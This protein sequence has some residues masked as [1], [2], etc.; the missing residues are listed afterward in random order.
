[1]RRS[2]SPWPSNCVGVDA[3]NRIRSCSAR[4]GVTGAILLALASY[5]PNAD[6][7]E[8]WQMTGVFALGSGLQGGDVGTGHMSFTRARLRVLAGVDL[9]TDESKSDGLGIYGFTEIEHRASFGGEVR[10]ERWWTSTIECH[11]MILGTVTPETMIGAG[12]GA[13]FGFPLGK[14]T[15]LFLEPGFAAFPLGSDLPEKSVL[16][17]GTLLGGVSLAL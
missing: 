10:Y 8:G 1:M 12:V 5:A 6:A 7:D 3:V 17:W 9:R 16:V 2:S 13:R 15:S 14:R 11:A 4:V